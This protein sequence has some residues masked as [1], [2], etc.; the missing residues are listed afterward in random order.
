MLKRHE[1]E[2]L[3][4]AGHAKAEVAR[5][6]GV[7]VHS[8]KRI[9]G[10]PSVVQVDDGAE[11]EQRRIGRPSTVENFQK[12]VNGIWKRSRSCLLWKSCGGSS[13]QA[14]GEARRLSMPWWL[15]CG[16]SK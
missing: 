4:K 11:R 13:R 5:L 15:L 8:V 6:A 9:A 14:M 12:L 3:L 1:V 7:S 10:E 16:P 2:I